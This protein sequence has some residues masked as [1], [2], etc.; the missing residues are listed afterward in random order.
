MK[1]VQAKAVIRLYDNLVSKLRKIWDG[2]VVA[3]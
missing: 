1:Y 3:T 2:A